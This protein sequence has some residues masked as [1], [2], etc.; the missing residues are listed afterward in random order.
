MN[1]IMTMGTAIN[2]YGKS[3]TISASWQDGMVCGNGRIGVVCWGSPYDERYVFQNMDFLVPSDEPRSV[4]PEVSAELE[5]AR[6]AVLHCDDTWDVHG[7]SRTYM[8]CFH[9]GGRLHIRLRQERLDHYAQW[10]L[11]IWQTNIWTM[12][13]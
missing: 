4:P 13:L 3:D 11:L 12:I 5:E 1:K 2:M 8:Y 6:Q 7:R 10:M 9:P